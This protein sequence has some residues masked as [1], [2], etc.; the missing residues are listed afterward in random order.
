MYNKILSYNENNMYTIGNNI[1]NGFHFHRFVEQRKNQTINYEGTYIW[2]Y[3][4]D[5][6]LIR[7]KVFLKD[8]IS[9]LSQ[10]GI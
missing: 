2:N 9:V 7:R 10:Y 6:L 8:Q 5:T 1:K 3:S 4:M